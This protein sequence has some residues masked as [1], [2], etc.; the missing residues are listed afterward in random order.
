MAARISDVQ[1]LALPWLVAE[2]LADDGTPLVVA[3]AYAT[4]WKTR[5]AYRYSVEI[6]VYAD[7][8]RRSRGLGRQL[9]EAL[10]ERLRSAG[11]HA[12]VGGICL[13]N[14]DSV[15]LHEKMG[16]THIGRFR[17][18]GYK[19]GQWLDVGYWQKIF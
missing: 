10:F 15:A 5:A 16:M 2:Q 12:A 7:H 6:T 3:Y 18:I 8:T 9:Y 19:A 4:R 14:D 1:G 17:E 11:V 13:P